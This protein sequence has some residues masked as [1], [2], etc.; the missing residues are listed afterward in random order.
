MSP[1][2]R[3]P[4]PPRV[5]V[6]IDGPA[7][8]GKS[9][10]ASAV[11]AALGVP[12]IDTGAFYRAATLAALRADV[13]VEDEE[14]VLAVVRAL[15]VERRHGRTLLAGEDVEDEIRGTAVT[16]AVSTVARHPRVRQALLAAQRDGVAG[17][18]A[19]VEGRDAGTVVVP[20]AALKVWLDA[21]P[22]E[23]GR[24]RALQRGEAGAVPAHVADVRRRDAAD[25]RQ[26][27]RADGA[28]VVD[29]TGRSL[30]DVVAEVV[31][32]ALACARGG[33]A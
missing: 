15:R 32:L 33:A 22:E 26:M 5:V 10:V 30:D 28:V 27:A 19:V 11:A 7:G 6:A 23:R 14:A 24:R 4:S 16:G 1:G 29:T 2:G 3:A 21:T 12:H 25:A 18:G 9:S 31:A 17:S 20:D 8:S 13:P